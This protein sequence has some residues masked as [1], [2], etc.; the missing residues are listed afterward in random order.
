M[1]ETIIVS[2]TL[3]LL[4]FLT[5]SNVRKRSNTTNIQYVINFSS[6]KIVLDY[7]LER[8]YDIVNKDKM[9]LYNIEATKVSDEQFNEYAKE[10]AKLTIVL[11]GPMFQKEFSNLFGNEETFFSNL[12]EFFSTRY[13]DDSV[14][15]TAVE[16]LVSE[17]TEEK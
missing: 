6:Y 17:E 3:A 14:R 11:M 7:F 12:M 2:C 13:E 4:I 1:I 10:F 5:L 9:L 8:A 15:K 16:S